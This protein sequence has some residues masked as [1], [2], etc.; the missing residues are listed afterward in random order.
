LD[1]VATALLSVELPPVP[2]RTVALLRVGVVTVLVER[3]GVV[4]PD[5]LR[6]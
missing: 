6:V 3:V 1:G 5:V 2:A 4:V